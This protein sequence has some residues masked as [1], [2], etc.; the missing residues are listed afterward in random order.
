MVISTPRPAR[1]GAASRSEGR[2]E[3]SRKQQPGARRAP[4]ERDERAS[5]LPRVRPSAALSR[6][7]VRMSSANRPFATPALEAGRGS[8]GRGS[9]TQ[10]SERG[11]R[12]AL[13]WRAHGAGARARSSASRRFE[14]GVQR[15][16]ARRR[17]GSP[18]K[19]QSARR[20]AAPLWNSAGHDVRPRRVIHP[21]ELFGEV[22][23]CVKITHGGRRRRHDA[24][25]G[26][27]FGAPAACLK[28]QR[29]Q[30]HP[31]AEHQTRHAQNYLT[32]ADKIVQSPDAIFPA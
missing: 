12:A 10:G 18:R 23:G 13:S 6:T 32:H 3:R 27:R 14:R 8:V 25:R 29:Q 2:I 21:G 17:S 7:W 9:P 24:R 19:P 26:G 16:T 11:S 30:K 28:Q 1:R 22:V 15:R 31:E 20:G 5:Q 4:P